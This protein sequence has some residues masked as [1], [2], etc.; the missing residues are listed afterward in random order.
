MIQNR[1]FQRFG[2]M[3]LI[4]NCYVHTFYGIEKTVFSFLG[5]ICVTSK[6]MSSGCNNEV[7]SSEIMVQVFPYV[8]VLLDKLT[9]RQDSAYLRT[10]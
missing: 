5:H 8:I 1:L 4:R 7:D 6:I 9:G 10:M 3:R 2:H